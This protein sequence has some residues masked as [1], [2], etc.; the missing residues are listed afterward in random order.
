MKSK[1]RKGSEGTEEKHPSPRNKF[2]QLR[3]LLSSLCCTWAT[4]ARFIFP[5]LLKF[6]YCPVRFGTDAVLLRR[7]RNLLRRRCV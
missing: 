3:P 2:Q 4:S 6:Y 7:P 1:G 5:S